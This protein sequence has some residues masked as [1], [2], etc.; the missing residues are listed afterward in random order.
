MKFVI[1]KS[2]MPRFYSYA[3][4]FVV[5]YIL[6]LVISKFRYLCNEKRK[7]KNFTFC[8]LLLIP[9]WR[10]PLRY[11]RADPIRWVLSL[12]SSFRPS[13]IRNHLSCYACRF[14][15]IAYIFFADHIL[16]IA[17]LCCYMCWAYFLRYP[18]FYCAWRNF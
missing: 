18:T 7:T 4:T 9:R 1:D 6:P 12:F 10:N 5:K 11:R 2:H 13:P 16:E 14:F 17:D 8:K 15:K 3:N